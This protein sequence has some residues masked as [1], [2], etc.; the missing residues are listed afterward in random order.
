M[1][2]KTNDIVTNLLCMYAYSYSYQTTILF[3]IYRSSCIDDEEK[4][5][6]VLNSGHRNWKNE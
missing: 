5:F 4:T 2:T 6:M 3:R 1:E